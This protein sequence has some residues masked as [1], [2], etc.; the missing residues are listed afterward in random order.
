MAEA[1]DGKLLWLRF[2]L[3]DGSTVEIDHP[4]EVRLI[5][6]DPFDV[7]QRVAKVSS[8]PRLG[9]GRFLRAKSLKG[10]VRSLVR[11]T[12]GWPQSECRGLCRQL[13]ARI[14]ARGPSA[15]TALFGCGDSDE[16]S[17][18]VR[19]VRAFTRQRL[20][21]LASVPPSATAEE[22]S[23]YQEHYVQSFARRWSE[24]G[25][26]PQ[27]VLER[28]N[29]LT[30]REIQAL[31]DEERAARL[32]QRFGLS[33]KLA[34]RYGQGVAPPDGP[35]AVFAWLWLNGHWQG[36]EGVRR[37]GQSPEWDWENTAWGWFL[38]ERVIP[39]YPLHRALEF[40]LRRRLRKLRRESKD[41]FTN[42]AVVA[43]LETVND[44]CGLADYLQAFISGAHWHGGR[45][46]RTWSTR[47]R[48]HQRQAVK[49][50][51]EGPTDPSYVTASERIDAVPAPP[52]ADPMHTTEVDLSALPPAER[53]AV[54]E[55]L[56]AGA[57]GYHRH[58]KQGKSLKD[59]WGALYPA[60]I[61]A[62]SRAR[63]RA[64]LM[65]H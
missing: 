45:R 2:H 51:V 55:F 61:R 56:A 30:K 37:K 16:E 57:E 48:G 26:D 19:L 34:Q 14:C 25:E 39:N 9:L 40:N 24:P 31:S 46:G 28:L 52:E 23:R 12:W 60:R 5:A 17:V 63:A 10:L 7:G 50:S 41:K 58:S 53:Q 54:E 62:L 4:E 64:K 27:A 47:L 59:W 21:A 22:I 20:M 6:V 15:V 33:T 36:E 35:L 8:V 38:R 18:Y 3:A 49:D 11:A 65:R 32:Q 43:V 1:K 44:A 13:A 42:L 29:F